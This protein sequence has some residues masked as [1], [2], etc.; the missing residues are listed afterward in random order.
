ML[1]D[2]L[3][4]VGAGGVGREAAAIV[5]AMNASGYVQIELAGV[6]DD[7]PTAANE[8]RLRNAGVAL[9]GSVDDVI[10][11]RSASAYVVAIGD[12]SARMR[13]ANR[14]DAAGWSA[15]TLVHP[16]A[17]VGN[18]VSIG[19]GSIVYPGATLTTHI[20][21]GRHVHINPNVT[22]GHDTKIGDFVSLNPQACVSG[23][24]Q[25]GDGSLI[26]ASALILQ[27]LRVGPAAVVGGAACVVRDVSSGTV[28]KGV[29]AS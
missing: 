26:G 17:T 10:A 7:A 27:G 20:E 29:P 18:S 28:V 4:I 25:I 13:I 8:H 22:V 9:L 5:E 15:L 24:C 12:P 21:V 3:V 11:E 16:R 19:Q 2:E 14:M 6:A 23:D 1:T